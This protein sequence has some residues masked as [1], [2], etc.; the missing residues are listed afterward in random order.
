[1]LDFREVGG[2][3]DTFRQKLGRRPTFDTHVLDE[4]AALVAKRA[5]ALTKTQELQTEKNQQNK[6]LSK[7]FKSGTDEEKAKARAAQKALSDAIKENEDGATRI[8]TEL[9]GLMLDIPNVPHDSVPDGEDESDNVV[10]RTW[11]QVPRFDFE[12]LDH[13]TIAEQG[14]RQIDFER[15]AKMSGARFSVSYDDVARLE[16]ALANFMLDLHTHEH[17]YR[18]VSVPYLVNTD[19]LTTTGQLPKFEADQFKVPF[20]ESTDYW[21]IPTAEV[22]LTNLFADSIVEAELPLAFCAHTPCFRKEA[23]SAGRDTRGMLRQHQFHKVELVRFAQPERSFDELEQLVSHAAAVLER[24]GLHHR[25]SLLCAGDMSAN[26]AKCYDL[27]VWL[28]GQSEY[29]EISSCSNVTDYQ[30]RRGKIRFREGPKGKPKL[31]HTLN[32]SGVAI[33]RCAI[34]VIE[35]YQRADGTVEVPEALRPYLGNRKSLGPSRND[36]PKG[37]AKTT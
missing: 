18:E 19:A 34:A 5:Q 11:G 12:P 7:I 3:L 8:E 27:E 13:V 6:T 36:R 14:W 25:V 23:G 2:D 22:P 37:N 20:N 17:G 30:A 15:A 21:L 32:G 1:M 26:A 28:P 9:H 10:V 31:V 24:L 29:R 4:V 35:Q 16:R 33:G